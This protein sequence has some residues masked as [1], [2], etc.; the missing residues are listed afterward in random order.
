MLTNDERAHL[1]TI[2]ERDAADE[3]LS[4]MYYFITGRSPE[5]SNKFG[6][7]EALDDVD[8]AQTTLREALKN[9][10]QWRDI[11]TAPKDGTHILACDARVPYGPHWGFNHRPPTVVH[12]WANPG[13]EG[14]YTSVNETEPLAPFP[15]THWK[16]LGPEP[17]NQTQDADLCASTG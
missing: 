14:F 7:K 12:W 8:D 6:H 1:Q 15:A 13:E 16:P 2:Y 9:A 3:C 17:S 11:A 10:T 5:W 4:Q